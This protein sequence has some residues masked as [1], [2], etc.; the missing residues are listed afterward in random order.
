MSN[1]SQ[2][3][4]TTALQMNPSAALRMNPDAALR[5]MNPITALEGQRPGNMPAQGNAL[6]SGSNWFQALKG[7]PKRRRF[8]AQDGSPFQGFVLF[9]GMTQGVALGWHGLGLWPTAAELNKERIA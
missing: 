8:S 5:M 9:Y 2:M 1:E 4:P 7:R 6:G 3:K